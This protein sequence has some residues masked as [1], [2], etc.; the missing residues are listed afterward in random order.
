MMHG[1]NL[2]LIEHHINSH[3][4]NFTSNKLAVGKE[5]TPFQIIHFSN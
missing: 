1:G 2:K 4:T 5:E 3:S